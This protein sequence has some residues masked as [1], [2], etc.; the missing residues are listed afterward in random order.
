MSDYRQLVRIS[1]NVGA[2]VN[3][4]RSA[5]EALFKPRDFLQE[6]PAEETPAPGTPS[7]V[8]KPRIL[9]ALVGPAPKPPSEMPAAGEAIPLSH[10]SRI[11]IWLDYGMTV[12]Q[13]ARVYGVAVSVVERL[14]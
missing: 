8:R 12:P 10:L 11:R 5:A 3:S 14:L 6:R 7:S 2:G 9:R 13:V 4:A 1:E